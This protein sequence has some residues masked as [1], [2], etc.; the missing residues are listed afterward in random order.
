MQYQCTVQMMEYKINIPIYV[1]YYMSPLGVYTLSHFAR[2]RNYQLKWNYTR[3]IIIIHIS[4][5]ELHTF[6]YYTTLE[7]LN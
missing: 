6:Y 5:M 1:L 3:F 4:V 7:E 2:N